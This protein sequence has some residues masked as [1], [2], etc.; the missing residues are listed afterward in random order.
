[1]HCINERPG[2]VAV[3]QRDGNVRDP[4]PRK[5][6]RRPRSAL[7]GGLELRRGHRHGLP[8]GLAGPHGERAYQH[9]G[10]TKAMPS[11]AKPQPEALAI[12]ASLLAR[13]QK[14]AR[15]TVNEH[16]FKD[17]PPPS[18][19]PLQ[20]RCHRACVRVAASSCTGP[21]A[22][23]GLRRCKSRGSSGRARSSALRPPLKDARLKHTLF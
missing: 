15:Q 14:D 11:H 13:D 6:R 16:D 21:R 9:A 10:H 4:L 12:K 7:R 17:P 22:E 18:P 8:Y 23:W 20:I 3:G 1:M 19:G 5:G 2:G